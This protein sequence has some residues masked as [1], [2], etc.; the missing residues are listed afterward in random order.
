MFRGTLVVL[1]ALILA[2]FRFSPEARGEDVLRLATDVWLPYEDISNDAAPGFSVEVIGAVLAQM[3]VASTIRE[4]P[5]ARGLEDVYEGKRDA[6]FTAFQTEE[7]AAHCLFP[8]EPLTSEK[9]VFF[10]R[11]DEAEALAFATYD[12]IRERRI[13]I[14]RGASVTEGFWSF[15]EE[16]GNYEEVETDDLNFKKLDRGRLDY[17][18]TSYSNGVMLAREL[19]LADVIEPLPSPVIKEDDLFIMFSRKTVS[20]DFVERF[21]AALKAFKATEDYGAIYDKY[22][23]LTAE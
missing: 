12:E 2:S 7:R 1:F 17:V 16:H 5:W 11:S 8:S 14:L 23:A 9:W 3:G 15:V 20:P 22:F 13:G 6:L 19:G 4:T 18:V 10:V 21:S